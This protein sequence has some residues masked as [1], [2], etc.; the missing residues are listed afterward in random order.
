[1][2]LGLGISLVP[3]REMAAFPRRHQLQRI[4]LPS[5]FARQLVVLTRRTTA[6]LPRHLQAFVDSILFS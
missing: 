5:S 6:G 3:Q 2:A 1:V 4:A